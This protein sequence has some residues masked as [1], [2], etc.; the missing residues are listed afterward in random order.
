[1]SSL[2]SVPVTLRNG[3]V[4]EIR[5][6]SPDDAQALVDFHEQLS[7]RTIYFRHFAA[8]P[9]LTDKEV[10]R[11]T[12]VDHF[13]REAYVAL[14]DGC[15][16]GVGRWDAITEELAEVA[17]VI[18]D[19]YQGQGLGSVLFE[20]LAQSAWALGIRQ[21]VADM[22]PQNRGMVRLMEDY[23]NVTSRTNQEGVVEIVVELREMSGPTLTDTEIGDSRD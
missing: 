13:A 20:L 10:N 12:N 23:G 5:P 9:H 1:M 3:E 18:R 2:P 7:D 11:F 19:D 6:I 21:F 15:I 22:L 17:F 16:L 8:R 14:R 4:L